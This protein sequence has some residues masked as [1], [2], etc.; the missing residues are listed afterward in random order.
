MR[1][2]CRSRIRSGRPRLGIMEWKYCITVTV[3]S[4]LFVF[5]G[6]I[7]RCMYLITDILEYRKTWL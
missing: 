3:L 4:R 7:Y 5:I 1:N 2:N 6:W